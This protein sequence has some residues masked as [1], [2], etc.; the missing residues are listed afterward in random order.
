MELE[1]GRVLDHLSLQLDGADV[2]MKPSP[3]GHKASAESAIEER[4]ARKANLVEKMHSFS[5]DVIIRE[6][7]AVDRYSQPPPTSILYEQGNCILL[8]I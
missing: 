2:I 7:T 4:A 3:S 5:L 8:A 1:G 6:A